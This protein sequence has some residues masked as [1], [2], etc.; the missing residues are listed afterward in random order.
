MNPTGNTILITGG[1]S[2]IGLA[3]ARKLVA[4]RNTVIVCGR[5][6]T[7]LSEAAQALPGLITIRADVTDPAN[8]AALAEETTARFPA[9]NVLINNAGVVNVT[10]IAEADFVRVLES[11]IATNLL[12][13]VALT[14]LLL[15]VLRDQ[16]Q[17]T[18]V[19]VTTGYVFISS[20]RTAPY[21]ATKMALHSLTQ[22]LRYQLRKTNI[23]VL[24]VMPP[25]T[26][27]KMAAHYAGAKAS[28]DA[29]ADRFLRAMFGRKNEVVMGVSRVAQALARL[30]P[31]I[32]FKILNDLETKG[33]VLESSRDM[34][35]PS[36]R[37]QE[38]RR[39]PPEHSKQE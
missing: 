18:V 33:S 19:N 39:A 3:V 24:E 28:A 26:D 5:D 4:A 35:P 12:A 16:P 21:S 8:R 31:G 27:T 29:V 6:Q 13:P 20:A 14:A 10:D 7:K 30:G 37:S 34:Q 23:R 15:P 2:G 9:L 17:A 11:E 32:G 36:V 22:T 38:H 25:P 1:A